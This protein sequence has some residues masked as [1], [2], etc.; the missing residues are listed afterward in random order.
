LKNDLYTQ[1]VSANPALTALLQSRSVLLLQGP[2]E[3]FF[4]RLTHWLKGNGVP[5]VNRVAFS[6]G[7]EWD[8]NASNCSTTCL[9]PAS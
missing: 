9:W 4:D 8:C 1:T 6:G 5:T 3:P 7:D 2:V